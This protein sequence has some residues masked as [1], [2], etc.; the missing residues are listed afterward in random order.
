MM[1]EFAHCFEIKTGDAFD[2]KRRQI[3]C[4]AHIVNL[5]TQAI[6]SARSKSKYYNSNPDDNYI[7][8]DLGAAL[9]DEVGI[10]RAICIKV[11]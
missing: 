3:R 7:P 5:A 6:I 4:L 1:Q 8:D 9:R 10:V 11:R 2:V